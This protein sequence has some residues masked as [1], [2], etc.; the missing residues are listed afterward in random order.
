[1]RIDVDRCDE[2]VVPA[3]KASAEGVNRSDSVTEWLRR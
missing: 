1:M 2:V 3:W